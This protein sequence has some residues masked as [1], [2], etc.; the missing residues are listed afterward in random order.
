MIMAST[1]SVR[2]TNNEKTPVCCVSMAGAEHV[3]VWRCDGGLQNAARLHIEDARLV[4]V[5][6]CANLCL[7]GPV[8]VSAE[9]ED[10][11]RFSTRH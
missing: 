2:A 4:K 8:L 1:E 6:V 11:A 5:R 7:F 3:A 9:E 10:L